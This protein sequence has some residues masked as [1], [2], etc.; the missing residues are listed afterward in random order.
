VSL[1]VLGHPAPF[2]SNFA[3]VATDDALASF[4]LTRH[5]IALGHRQIAYFAG[6]PAVPAA[7]EQFEGYRRA[8]R[9]AEIPFD[10]RLIFTAGSSIED[11]SRAAEQMLSEMTA[12]T[13]VQTSSDLV[14][15]GAAAVFHAA[16][17][18]IPGD[19]SLTGFGDHSAAE[20]LLPPL[21]TA[22]LPKYA[23]GLA[24][25]DQMLRLFQNE[26]AGPKRLSCDVVLRAST[27]APA[28]LNIPASEGASHVSARM[29]EGD[30]L[31]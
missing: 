31:E 9:E 6:P 21:S 10:D 12:A 4:Q 23:L 2:A 13:A 26:L 17:Y 30:D 20:Y 24:A 19:L 15:M 29:A 28:E 16:G 25:V 5:L 1:V 7:Q 22:R 14:A 18:R 27:A 8:L 11:G 3:S